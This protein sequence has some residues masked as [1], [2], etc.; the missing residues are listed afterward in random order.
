MKLK[1]DENLGRLAAELFS[2]AGHDV[3]TV[4]SQNLHSA[5]DRTLIER[6]RGEGRCL[7]TLDLDFGNPLLFRPAD[8]AGIVVLRL[9]SKPSHEDLIACV[10]TLKAALTTGEMT[11]RLWVVQ[12]GQVRQYQ[13]PHGE[14]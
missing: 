14:T 3:K 12:R 5:S 7:I 9:P 11:G 6:C 13:D 2:A 8:Y 1:M 4:P 10:D